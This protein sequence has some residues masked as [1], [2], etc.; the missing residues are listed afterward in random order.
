MLRL[1]RRLHVGRKWSRRCVQKL[2]AD[3]DA[4]ISLTVV[5]SPS[6]GSFS[7]HGSLEETLSQFPSKCILQYDVSFQN[8]DRKAD[9]SHCT[10]HEKPYSQPS[11][12]VALHTAQSSRTMTSDLRF[13]PC[14][15]AAPS[16]PCSRLIRACDSF[17][18]GSCL[19]CTLS[20]SSSCI[21]V[22]AFQVPSLGLLTS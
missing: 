15:R 20:A 5:R 1:L 6:S 17:E 21:M 4:F 11:H 13:F 3:L 10:N 9:Q 18:M 8:P 12:L 7:S 22:S 16:S 14:P 2:D 19:I